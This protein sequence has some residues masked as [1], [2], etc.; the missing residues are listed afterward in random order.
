MLSKQIVYGEKDIE[1]AL[2]QICE[3]LLTRYPQ[4]DEMVLVGVRTGGVFLAERLKPKI[5]QKKGIDLP[6]HSRFG[7]NGTRRGTSTPD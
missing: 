7:S 5:L 2:N 3:Q 6:T 4:L 1:V